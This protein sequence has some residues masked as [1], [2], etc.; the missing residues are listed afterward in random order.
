MG[1]NPT[2]A[3]NGTVRQRKSGHIQNMVIEGSTPSRAT[4][5]KQTA[6][7]PAL[8]APRSKLQ[9]HTHCGWARSQPGLISQD[10]RVRPPDPLL[11]RAGRSVR[12][13]RRM[14]STERLAPG[15]IFRHTQQTTQQTTQRAARITG[16][17]LLCTQE[18]GV[19]FSGGPLFRKVAGYGLP[20]LAANECS[21][22]TRSQSSNLWPSA[23]S[24][25][26]RW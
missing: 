18:I 25:M 11:Q 19:R 5:L 10:R 9:T 7:S 24:Q 6:G 15:T 8:Q 17:H 14:I 4:C 12:D 20:G 26:A 3:T 23:D 21:L 13:L 2:R 1:S 22:N 16:R